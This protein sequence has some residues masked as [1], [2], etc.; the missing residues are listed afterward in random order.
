MTM[1]RLEQTYA[2]ID[3]ANADERARGQAARERILSLA[4]SLGGTLSGEHG[5]GLAKLPFLDR[6]LSPVERGLMARIKA[7]FDPYGIMNPG[8]AY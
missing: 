5:V 4:L 7:A 2:L 3:A 6:Q 8:K 1:S